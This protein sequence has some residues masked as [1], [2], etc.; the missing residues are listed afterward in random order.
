M[1]EQ[2]S[3]SVNCD[4]TRIPRRLR[5]TFATIAW[6]GFGTFFALLYG[7]PVALGYVNF[8]VVIFLTIVLIGLSFLLRAMLKEYLTFKYADF[9]TAEIINCKEARGA[10]GSPGYIITYRFLNKDGESVEAKTGKPG[11]WVAWTP[12]SGAQMPREGEKSLIFYSA[13]SQAGREILYPGVFFH[14][15]AHR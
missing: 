11:S 1:N 8:R 6:C 13:R 4:L 10:K 15:K 14:L 2:N 9:A 5:P 12:E 7:L 3:A